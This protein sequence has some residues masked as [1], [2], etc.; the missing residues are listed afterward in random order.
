MT[1]YIM[2]VA[3]TEPGLTLVHQAQARLGLSRSALACAMLRR[4]GDQVQPSTVPANRPASMGLGL[5][6]Q[7]RPYLAARAQRLGV[8]RSKF[9]FFLFNQFLARAS[10]EIPPS[11]SLRG[12]AYPVKFV[13]PPEIIRRIHAMASEAKL[14]P[15][16]LVDRLIRGAEHIEAART[17]KIRAQFALRE[18]ARLSGLTRAGGWSCRSA[19]LAHLVEQAAPSSSPVDSHKNSTSLPP[20]RSTKQLAPAELVA[21][22]VREVYEPVWDEPRKTVLVRGEPAAGVMNRPNT[23]IQEA[24]RSVWQ[25]WLK[26]QK[27]PPQPLSHAMWQR[28]MKSY[29]YAHPTARSL[30]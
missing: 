5:E 23:N 26:Q 6:I 10:E 27:L 3:M 17:N 15:P 7:D 25:A 21:D 4:Y 28:A 14:D 30:V 12:S 9:L 16:V 1:R 11:K 18:S 29:A 22:F 13:L 19:L 8:T 20:L 2:T 24:I